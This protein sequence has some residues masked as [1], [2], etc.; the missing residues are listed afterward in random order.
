AQDLGQKADQLSAEWLINQRVSE[1]MAQPAVALRPKEKPVTQAQPL[2]TTQGQPSVQVI[3]REPEK[4]IEQRNLIR[5]D[6]AQQN[7]NEVMRLGVFEDGTPMTA[8]QKRD[9]LKFILSKL[10]ENFTINWKAPE[11]KAKLY[12]FTDTT[13]PF[14]RRLHAS[15]DE[16]N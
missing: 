11:E 6:S 8:E 16:L 2:V 4:L 15:M 10:P 12:V 7:T 13:C 1:I 14:C 3:S 5:R 9:Q